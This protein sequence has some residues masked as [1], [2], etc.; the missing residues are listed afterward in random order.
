MGACHI[1]TN[2]VTSSSRKTAVA[3]PERLA[4]N[5]YASTTKPTLRAL[6]LLGGFPAW[7]LYQLRY[8]L[9]HN[10]AG[11]NGGN[12]K[13]KPSLVDCLVNSTPDEKVAAARK[14]GIDR[15]WDELIAP[16]LVED[17]ASAQAAE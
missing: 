15:V 8:R 7:R 12:G 10:G 14:F 16:V 6:A 3:R 9:K 1:S 5:I 2:P 11:R 17:K 13:P 4:L